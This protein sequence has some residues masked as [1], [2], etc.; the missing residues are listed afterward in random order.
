[1][2]GLSIAGTSLAGPREQAK[3]I[4]DRLAGIPPSEDTL[5]SME[6]DVASG[7]NGAI[8]AAYLAMEDPNFYNVT[9]KI[10]QRRGPTAKRTSSFH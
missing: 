4:H 10:L 1:M 9:L 2:L 3:R 6:T 7:Y 8:N 5:L